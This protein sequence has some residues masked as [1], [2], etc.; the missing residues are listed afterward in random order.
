MSEASMQHRPVDLVHLAKQTGGDRMLEEEV[1]NLFLKQA[2]NL[3]REMRSNRDPALRAK[4]AH[5]IKGAA[6]AVGAFEVAQCAERFEEKPGE[7]K[8]LRSLLQ[9]IDVTCDY[10]S[11]LL[12]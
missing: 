10:I 8:C 1:L 9:E 2:A 7:G 11:S 4:A 6:R 3:G 5:T 12:R